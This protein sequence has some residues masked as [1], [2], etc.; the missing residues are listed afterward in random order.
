MARASHSDQGKYSGQPKSNFNLS[1]V[2]V[3]A[4][5]QL[6]EITSLI[7]DEKRQKVKSKITGFIEETQQ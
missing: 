1:K 7:E 2:G 3:Q 5:K 4:F 6:V